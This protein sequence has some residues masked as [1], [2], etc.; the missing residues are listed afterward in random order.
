MNRFP[1]RLLFEDAL[2]HALVA[3]WRKEERTYIL[4]AHDVVEWQFWAPG[5]FCERC[6]T[7]SPVRAAHR[8]L[9]YIFR[10]G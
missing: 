8:L 2:E 4:F 6:P 9:N 7:V 5:S 1:L 3:D 10:Q